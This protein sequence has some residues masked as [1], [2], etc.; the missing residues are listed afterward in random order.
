MLRWGAWHAGYRF[1][2]LRPGPNVDRI[3]RSTDALD[4]AEG[5]V[6]T[7]GFSSGIRKSH[8]PTAAHR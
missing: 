6:L 8:I 3:I 7:E 5:G 1:L 4:A 2:E